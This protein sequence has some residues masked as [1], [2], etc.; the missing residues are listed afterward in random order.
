MKTNR[1]S[2]LANKEILAKIVKDNFSIFDVLRAFNL[3]AKG[4]AK[5]IKKYLNEFQICTAHFNSKHYL[6]TNS[7][8]R[9][10]DNQIFCIN[11]KAGSGTVKSRIIKNKLFPYKCRDCGNEGEWNNKKIVLQ[12]EH[13]NGVST[14][15]RIE[16]LTLLCPNCHSQTIT[17]AGKNLK[18]KI[19]MPIKYFKIIQVINDDLPQVLDNIHLYKSFED[20]LN[21]YKIKT[22]KSTLEK[23]KN[24]LLPYQN[25]ESIKI[26][27]A[28]NEIDKKRVKFPSPE[29]VLEMVKATNYSKTAKVLEC[30]DNGVRKYLKRNGLL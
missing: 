17:Y 3:N 6:L 27:Y 9:L 14:D 10:D 2:V 28:N 4:N 8:K 18:N 5:T 12:L 1:T 24:T 13:I 7:Y 11:S 21:S 29:K 30:S 15:N 19:I 26:F 16:N 20:F 25:N 23:L 22:T